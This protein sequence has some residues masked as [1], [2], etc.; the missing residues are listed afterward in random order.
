M[1]N[2]N[3]ELSA[4]ANGNGPKIEMPFRIFPRVIV[5]KRRKGKLEKYYDVMAIKLEKNKKAK[6]EEEEKNR[7][8]Y[9]SVGHAI[10]TPF[11]AIAKPF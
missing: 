9:H 7:K 6:E 2:S 3:L 10:A 11:R 5:N 8:W 4:H 1:E